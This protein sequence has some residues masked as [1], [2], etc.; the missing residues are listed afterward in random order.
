M[1][2]GF[3][4]PRMR[5]TVVSHHDIFKHRH[6]LVKA[7][8]LKRPADPQFRPEMW[9]HLVYSFFPIKDLSL[10]KGGYPAD[11]IEER[12]LSCSIGTDDRVNFAL[13]YRNGNIVK[14]AKTA[15]IFA[16]ISDFQDHFCSGSPLE[17][18]L[19]RLQLVKKKEEKTVDFFSSV[20]T[21]FG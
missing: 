10:G 18:H 7:H 17:T 1:E 20:G 11:Q 4:K 2:E 12:G 8:D 21:S 9:L 3:E 15:E 6:G 5:P 14:G 16:H 13:F 19:F